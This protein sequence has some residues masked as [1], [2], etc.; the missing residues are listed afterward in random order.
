MKDD[1]SQPLERHLMDAAP[2]GQ[3]AR[4]VW[5]A[6]RLVQEAGQDPRFSRPAGG[7]PRQAADA[8]KYSAQYSKQD[9]SGRMLH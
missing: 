7:A 2:K 5:P 6:G 3:S 4:Q 1:V 8:G 9:L